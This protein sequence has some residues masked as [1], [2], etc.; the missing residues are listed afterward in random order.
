LRYLY[1]YYSEIYKE[2]N[3]KELPDKEEFEEYAK[4][5]PEWA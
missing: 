1:S 3:N 2:Q 5:H 4:L